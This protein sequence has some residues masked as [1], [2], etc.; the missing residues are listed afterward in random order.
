M[1]N[2]GK[3]A[4]VMCEV[5]NT[6]LRKFNIPFQKELGH[7][8]KVED[9]G[10]TNWREGV[11]TA[12]SNTSNSWRCR[13]QWA[14]KNLGGRKTTSDSAIF[15]LRLLYQIQATRGD[16]VSHGGQWKNGCLLFVCL[17]DGSPGQCGLGVPSSSTW[18]WSFQVVFD[19]SVSEQAE[20]CEADHASLLKKVAGRYQNK[21]LLEPS[22]TLMQWVHWPTLYPQPSQM[23]DGGNHETFFGKT[24]KIRLITAWKK[25]T[26]LYLYHSICPTRTRHKWALTRSPICKEIRT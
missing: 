5:L 13:S 20:Y 25:K 2:S 12:V 15:K 22:F 4:W 18:T 14:M 7:K 21:F 26:V 24:R 17:F 3:E 8:R 6:G 9:S 16:H 19:T 11:K 10:S 1:T 23:F